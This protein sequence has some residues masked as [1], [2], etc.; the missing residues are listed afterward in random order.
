VLQQF[1]NGEVT[2]LKQDESKASYFGKRSPCDGLINWDWQKERVYNW[3][4]AQA[5]PYPGAF[6]FLRGKK[7]VIDQVAFDDF[8]YH[9]E[10]PNGLVL[11]LDPVRVKTPNGVLQLLNLRQGS[12]KIE[13]NDILQENEN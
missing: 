12:E 13:I 7:I 9:Q 1:K 4:R 10:Q 6:S 3:V 2:G 11:T 8:G 5:N